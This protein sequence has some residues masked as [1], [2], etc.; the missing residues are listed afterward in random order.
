MFGT[1]PAQPCERN[2]TQQPDQ[3]SSRQSC[4]PRDEGGTF[5]KLCDDANQVRAAEMMLRI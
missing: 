4:G 1:V 2:R 3:G 5:V